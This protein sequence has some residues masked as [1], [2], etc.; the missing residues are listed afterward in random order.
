MCLGSVDADMAN[1]AKAVRAGTNQSGPYSEFKQPEN[2]LLTKPA[3]L[4]LQ[5][6]PKDR[7]GV[8]AALHERG[9][10]FDATTPLQEDHKKLL[11]VEAPGFMLP[12]VASPQSEQS[13]AAPPSKSRMLKQVASCGSALPDEEDPGLAKRVRRPTM[14]YG[15]SSSDS[16]ANSGSSDGSESSDSSFS[17]SKQYYNG[18][19]TAIY[20][21]QASNRREGERS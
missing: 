15:E 10:I 12:I 3:M 13:V 6:R 16:E 5:K 19:Q 7:V 4:K 18:S 2:S 1:C 17:P 9:I 14:F 8:F 21:V 20:F 11:L